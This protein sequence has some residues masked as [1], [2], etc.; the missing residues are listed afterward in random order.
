MP[1]QV[2]CIPPGLAIAGSS[3]V[4]WIVVFRKV[5]GP[6]GDRL[7]ALAWG[8]SSGLIA[9]LTSFGIWVLVF[10]MTAYSWDLRNAFAL[11]ATVLIPMAGGIL[12]GPML[13]LRL[14]RRRQSATD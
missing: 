13:V 7:P 10:W 5:R 1:I 2:I 11:L 14:R 12:L 8:A 3:I 9:A 6:S 4:S